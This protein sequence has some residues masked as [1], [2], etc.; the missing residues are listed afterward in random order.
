MAE[1]SDRETPEKFNFFDDFSLHLL[2]RC[3]PL[4]VVLAVA[5]PPPRGEFCEAK[6]Q[7]EQL[8]VALTL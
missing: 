3:C 6:T 4:V 1:W 7:E 2:L 8:L 5:L